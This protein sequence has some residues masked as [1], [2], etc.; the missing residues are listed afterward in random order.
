MPWLS[1]TVMPSHYSW[2]V[3]RASNPGVASPLKVMRETS[4]LDRPNLRLR[5]G[6]LRPWVSRDHDVRTA[7][8]TLIQQT[9]ERIGCTLKA[10]DRARYRVEPVLRAHD[11][12]DGSLEGLCGCAT[13]ALQHQALAA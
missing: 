2:C 13:T 8:Y 4:K 9:F 3:A 11:N 1:A 7:R 12:F 5:I 6:V 10:V